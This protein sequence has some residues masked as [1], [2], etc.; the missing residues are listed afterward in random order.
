MRSAFYRLNESLDP[1]AKWQPC[2]R[3]LEIHFY[4]NAVFQPRSAHDLVNVQ[5]PMVLSLADG[6][7]GI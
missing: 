7:K 3:A 1:S 6:D 2:G 5:K 4:G